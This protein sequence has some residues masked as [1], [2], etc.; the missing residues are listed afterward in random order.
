MK[1]VTFTSPLS[2]VEVRMTL[3]ELCGSALDEFPFRGE[4]GQSSFTLVKN[5]FWH[6]SFTLPIIYG[7]FHEIDGGTNISINTRYKLFDLICLILSAAIFIAL[8]V[9][10]FVIA[11]GENPILA[12]ISATIILC[13]GEVLPLLAHISF[14]HKSKVCINLLKQ[15]FNG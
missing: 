3:R 1:A 7:Q 13:F 15:K 11:I 9:Y 10:L 5:R 4:V 2:E 6:N 14:L 8:A 12:C